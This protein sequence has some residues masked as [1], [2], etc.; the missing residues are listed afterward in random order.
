MDE[1]EI[2]V[3]ET[4][5]TATE[6]RKAKGHAVLLS[7]GM[8]EHPGSAPMDDAMRQLG[9][10]ESDLLGSKADEQAILAYRIHH[11]AWAIRRTS[12]DEPAG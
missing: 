6:I 12:G 11:K 8:P 5:T 9:I 10:S 3:G 7:L 1:N 4:I 2:M